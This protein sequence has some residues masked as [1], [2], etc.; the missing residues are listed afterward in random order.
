MPMPM[1]VPVADAMHGLG[2]AWSPTAPGLWGRRGARV[3]GA[4]GV[5]MYIYIY[6]YVYSHVYIYIYF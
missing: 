5:C 2:T 3:G 1:A 6:M 4:E